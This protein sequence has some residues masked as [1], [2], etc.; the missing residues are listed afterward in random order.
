MKA[1]KNAYVCSDCGTRYSK[2]MGRCTECGTLNSVVELVT[3]VEGE[4]RVV[5]VKDL[6]TSKALERSSLRVDFLDR[7]MGGGLPKGTVVLLAGEP[8][9]GKS[10]LLFQML[11]EQ[12]TPS[13]YVSAEESVEQVAR[14][15]R[16]LKA[17]VSDQIYVLSESRIAQVIKKMDELKP[18]VVI[19]DSIQMMN[20]EGDDRVKGGMASL[21]EMTEILV[22]RAKA[23]G[24]SLWIVGHVNKDGDIA[25]PKTLEH[26]V[27]T[28][29]LFSSAEESQLRI[30]QVQKHRFGRSGE[31]ALL[32]MTESG[33]REKK[34]HSTYW[35]HQRTEKISGCALSPVI[36]GSRVLVVEIQALVVDTYFPSPRRST[37]GFDLNRLFLIL[38]VLEKRLRLPFSKS[39]VY[40]NV[41]GGLKISDPGADLAVG[42]ALVSALTEQPIPLGTVFCGE[43]GLTGELRPTYGLEERLR[44]IEHLGYTDWVGPHF[45]IPAKTKAR[46]QSFEQVSKALQFLHPY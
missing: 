6:D 35:V 8:G 40:L 23:L 32:E 16:S 31:L 39:D 13:L 36:M 20:A 5:R 4:S 21:R 15:F 44:T 24:M 27:D 34:E 12:K 38:A 1:L 14:R 18:E 10:T 11:L 45:K 28:V 29:L 33:L 37:S 25:G 7:V 17:E 3:K 41:V 9:I 2:W 30:L 42:A 19:I 22:Q 46:I 26:L 43:I